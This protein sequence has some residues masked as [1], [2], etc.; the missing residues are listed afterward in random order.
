M[1]NTNKSLFL[2]TLLATV[3]IDATPR[4][5]CKIEVPTPPTPS[6]KQQDKGDTKAPSTP[7]PTK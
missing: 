2:I 4:L 5:F 3:A 1:T 6:P 7:R